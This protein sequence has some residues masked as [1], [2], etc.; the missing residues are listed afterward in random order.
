M[1]AGEIRRCDRDS[2]ADPVELSASFVEKHLRTIA[3]R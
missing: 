2:C 3:A 1:S